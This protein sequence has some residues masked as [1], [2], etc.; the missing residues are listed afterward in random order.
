MCL[1]SF[2]V[3]QPSSDCL[4]VLVTTGLLAFLLIVLE[5]TRPGLLSPL[6][7]IC[8]LRVLNH[9]IQ[10]ARDA[11]VAMVRGKC[12]HALRAKSRR[13]LLQ[14]SCGP[15]ITHPERLRTIIYTNIITVLFPQKSCRQGCS[16][17][18]SVTVPQTRVEFD[19]WERKTVSNWKQLN[20]IKGTNRFRLAICFCLLW[21][22]LVNF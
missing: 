10:E 5:W 21:C 7:P 2:S 8:D 1:F 20:V 14:R 18:E 9:F 4:F 16:L 22:N 17:S 12:M 11:E 6:R 19:V 13:G 15:E 3:Q